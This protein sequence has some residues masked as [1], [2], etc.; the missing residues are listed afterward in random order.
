MNNVCNCPH[1]KDKWRHTQEGKF[2]EDELHRNMNLQ[3]FLSPDLL[4]HIHTGAL[5]IPNP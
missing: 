2:D 5:G 4:T 1:Y 3:S